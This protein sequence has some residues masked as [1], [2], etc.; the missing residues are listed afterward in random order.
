ML[1]QCL[2]SS[3]NSGCNLIVGILSRYPIEVLDRHVSDM[4][5][6]FF[7]VR[8]ASVVYVVTHMHAHD[9]RLREVEAVV[10]IN[11]ITRL[12]GA[13]VPVVIMGDFNT[14][15]P[16]D[17]NCYTSEGLMDYLFNPNV[18]VRT[19]VL[20]LFTRMCIHRCNLPTGTRPLPSKV[21]E[22]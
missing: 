18:R 19:R 5:R 14:L 9:A 8:I 15:S 12:V 10:L 4:E 6:G 11:T 3:L 7:A 17:A 13:A 20:L 16:L 22:S 2:S 21:F 1:P